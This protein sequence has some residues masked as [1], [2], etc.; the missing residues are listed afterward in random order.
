MYNYGYNYGY[1]YDSLVGASAGFAALGAMLIVYSI[2]VIAIAV[3]QIVAM[4]KIFT[5]AGEEGWKAII[6]IYNIIILFKISGISP[7]FVLVYLA[8]IIPFVGWIAVL[9]MTIY[10]NYN[11]S[12]A[13]GKDVGFTVGLCLVAPIFYLILGF[14]KA[15]YVGTPYTAPTNTAQ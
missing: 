12:K 10:L 9:G 15:E 14:G 4:W 13:F 7:L 6:P 11:L 2:I 3:L 1:D 8:A 5:K